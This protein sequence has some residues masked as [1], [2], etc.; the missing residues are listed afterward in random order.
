MANITGTGGDD[1]NLV[2]TEFNDRIDALAGNDR[3]T[4][5]G[6]RDMIF[7]RAGDD[8]AV[9]NVATD[10][11]DETDLGSG[12]D[13]VEVSGA[14][15]VR[16]TFTSA[17]VGN[18]SA[19]DSD[20]LTNQD[21]GLAV[22][23]RAE[24]AA[25]SLIGLNSR[26][27]DEGITFIAAAGTTFDVRDLVSGVQRG[28]QFRVATLGTA[29]SDTLGALLASSSYYFNAGRGN[30]TVT[31]SRVDDFLVGGAGNDTLSGDTGDDRFIGG[32]G[33]DTVNGGLGDDTA[34]FNVATD[35]VD[36]TDLGSGSDVVNVSGAA[37]VRL[38]FTSA[39]VG[40][41]NALDSDSLAN[42]D[43]G[44]AVRLR[45]ENAAGNLIGLNSR[46]DDEG[47]TYVAAAGTTFDVRDLV[48]GVQRG[49]Q[50][51]VVTLGTAGS[52]ALSAVQADRSYYI[53]AGRGNDTLLGGDVND[54]LVGGAGNDRLDGGDGDDGFIGGAGNDV[55]TGGEGNDRATFNVATDGVDQTDLGDG[56]DVVNVTATGQVRL[57]FT[58]AE[59]GNGNALD[60]GTLANQDGGLAVRLRAEDGSDGLA[61]LASRFDDEGV[62]FVASAGAAFDVRDLVSGVQRGDTFEVVTLGTSDD[63]VLTAIQADRPYY[64]NAGQGNDDVTGGNAADFL[65]GGAGNDTLSGGSGNDKFIGGGGDDDVDGGADT[66]RAI[67]NVASSDA[68][69]VFGPNN[70][71]TITSTEG[72]DTYR[73][74]EEFQFSDGV[75]EFDQLPMQPFAAGLGGGE[76]LA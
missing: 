46:F 20:T 30:D 37:Q 2:G 15:Q 55:V 22:R 35:G 41:G 26:F 60:A 58:S 49:D 72:V 4:G 39:E 62:T 61:G 73:N 66:D 33:N 3:I 36:Q 24:N 44:L 38:T 16:L 34:N 25:G 5:R 11:V 45:A 1:D 19:V 23:L 7:G 40:N 32:A 10:G 17:E 56:E 68:M 47:V 42:Q 9:F 59:V 27:D 14:S 12:S 43:G 75:F 69:F 21:G 48:S 28:D 57:T 54:F 67:L 13:A 70:S 64:F 31:G 65:V 29:G 74:V 6:G 63:D 52:D 18:G 50:F 8:T 53:N 76:L 51:E 71:V